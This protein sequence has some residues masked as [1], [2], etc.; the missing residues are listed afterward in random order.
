M[1]ALVFFYIGSYNVSQKF[2]E[3]TDRLAH[4]EVYANESAK[5]ANTAYFKCGL[6]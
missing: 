4:H 6:F 3:R 1:V 2:C 5:L